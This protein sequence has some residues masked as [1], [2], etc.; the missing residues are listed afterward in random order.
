MNSNAG[1]GYVHLGRYK[2]G[3]ELYPYIDLS[4]FR[5]YTKTLSATEVSTIYSAGKYSFSNTYSGTTISNL[6]VSI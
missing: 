4:D 6:R 1:T 3:N 5:I 2:D